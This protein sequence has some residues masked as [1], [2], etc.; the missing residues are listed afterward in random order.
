M[1]WIGPPAFGPDGAQDVSRAIRAAIDR[2]RGAVFVDELD[3]IPAG[4]MTVFS[5][6]GVAKRVEELA[7]VNRRAPIR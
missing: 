7:K 5:A 6:H 2:H 1:I 3:E 4:A